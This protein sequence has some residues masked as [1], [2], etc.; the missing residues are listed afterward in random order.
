[1]YCAQEQVKIKN[2][3]RL[4]LGFSVWEKRILHTENIFLP[5]IVFQQNSGGLRTENMSLRSVFS[6]NKI[7]NRPFGPLFILELV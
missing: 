4:C 7:Y 3:K 1:M 2:P 6:S 5:V